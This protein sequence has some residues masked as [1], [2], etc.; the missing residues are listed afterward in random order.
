MNARFP[1]FEGRFFRGFRG[2]SQSLGNGPDAH[3]AASH[4]SEVLKFRLR[5]D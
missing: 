4:V 2:R 5:E 1:R 3:P